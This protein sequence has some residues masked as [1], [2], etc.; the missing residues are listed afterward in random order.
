MLTRLLITLLL[1]TSSL[2]AASYE[3][4]SLGTSA[5]QIALGNIE[6][7]SDSA[8]VLFENPAGLQAINKISLSSFKATLLDD[9][10]YLNVAFALDT[11]LGRIGIGYLTNFVDGIPL[12]SERSYGQETIYGMVR[13]LNYF[14]DVMLISHQMSL[15]FMSIGYN[16]KAY[17]AALGEV[18]GEAFN[19]D[20]GLYFDKA[21]GLIDMSF[22]VKNVLLGTPY[23]YS[24]GAEE[25]VESSAVIGGRLALGLV[26]TYGQVRFQKDAEIK[27]SFQFGGQLNLVQV[28][29]L[30]GGWRQY[31][32][33]DT[34]KS[35]FSLGLSLDL[36]GI[37]VNYATMLSEFVSADLD[38]FFSVSFKY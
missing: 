2:Y 11:V 3:P 7:F 36:V 25:N 21:F 23:S 35:A 16:L 28:L 22:V 38:H 27:N 14:S 18:T 34:K 12:T 29:S 5:R 30:Y 19:G 9:V 20:V 4:S 32:A 37:Q 26:E 13:E 1:L 31:W 10:H 15:G 8:A 24:N 6:G 17:K 33:S